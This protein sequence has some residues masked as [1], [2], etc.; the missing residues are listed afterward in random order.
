ML[1]QPIHNCL[2]ANLENE[3]YKEKLTEFYKENKKLKEQLR[4][5][6][7]E[8]DKLKSVQIDISKK[9]D[10]STQTN[11]KEESKKCSVCEKTK[12][13]SKT[14]SLENDVYNKQNKVSSF[15]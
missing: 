8:N 6:L 4:L 12:N 3:Y 2:Q 10:S 13:C 1:A 11:C 5:A 14:S 9:S 15:L 7:N